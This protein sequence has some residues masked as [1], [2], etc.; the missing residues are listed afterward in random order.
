MSLVE[1]VWRML[2]L[3]DLCWLFNGAAAC[4][5]AKP[6]HSG[7][8][9]MAASL[10]TNTPTDIMYMIFDRLPLSSLC[11][12][13]LVCKWTQEQSL[14][15]FALRVYKHNDV[16]DKDGSLLRLARVFWENRALAS[17]VRTLKVRW[18]FYG[19]G[20]KPPKMWFP[21][22][23]YFGHSRAW[24]KHTA[25]LASVPGLERL[26]LDGM[27]DSPVLF[28][29]HLDPDYLP[30]PKYDL[31]NFWPR[32]KVLSFK[33]VYLSH[34]NFEAMLC[35]L[36]PALT[37]LHLERVG[38]YRGRWVE[39]LRAIQEAAINLKSLRLIDVR[40]DIWRRV[41]ESGVDH[42]GSPA[43]WERLF[44]FRF[45]GAKLFT[46]FHGPAGIET[47]SLQ[48]YD[49]QMVGAHAIKLGLNMIAEHTAMT[50]CTEDHEVEEE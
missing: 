16:H 17:V 29:E 32:I 30:S 50:Q 20:H 42:E 22:R 28:G 19:R 9:T 24:W 49:A 21:R 47:L 36:S 6:K 48:R 38:C 44:T 43:E 2:D 8:E 40:D 27:T 3:M 39:T 11:E 15:C 7:V 37:E 46:T 18:Q 23:P 13:R 25:M 1:K 33:N 10:L 34:R 26:E 41:K 14:K 5:R 4:M 35:A 31:P 45:E 12:F